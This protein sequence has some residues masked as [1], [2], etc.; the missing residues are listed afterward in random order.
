MGKKTN[1]LLYIPKK[2]NNE[3]IQ[4][5]TEGVAYRQ[6]IRNIRGAESGI[7]EFEKN[8]LSQANAQEKL[9]TSKNKRDFISTNL[10]SLDNTQRTKLNTAIDNK[11]AAKTSISEM[12]I[13][14]MNL[15]V[16]DKQ[17]KTLD[18]EI[19]KFYTTKSTQE[20]IAKEMLKPGNANKTAEEILIPGTKSTQQGRMEALDKLMEQKNKI[21]GKYHDKLPDQ[22]KDNQFKAETS[23]NEIKATANT[24]QKYDAKYNKNLFSSDKIVLSENITTDGKIRKID[25][26]YKITTDKTTGDVTLENTIKNKNDMYEKT[27]IPK[28][29]PDPTKLIDD[30]LNPGKQIIDPKGPLVDNPKYAEIQKVINGTATNF[31]RRPINIDKQIASTHPGHHKFS[32][33]DVS[34]ALK[35]Q[36]GTGNKIK[37]AISKPKLFEEQKAKIDAAKKD[38]KEVKELAN[39]GKPISKF[40]K[41]ANAINNKVGK[42]IFKTNDIDKLQRA[43]K[44]VDKQQKIVESKAQESGKSLQK[45][46]QKS[47]A[48][49]E[50]KNAREAITAIK[51]KVNETKAKTEKYEQSH[52]WRQ[53]IDKVAQVAAVGGAVAG[54]AAGGAAVAVAPVVGAAAFL[55]RAGSDGVKNAAKDVV[56]GAQ[57]FAKQVGGAALTAWNKVV[58]AAEFIAEKATKTPKDFSA[59][60]AEKTANELLNPEQTRQTKLNEKLEKFEKEGSTISTAQPAPDMRS[61]SEKVS[62]SAKKAVDAVKNIPNTIKKASEVIKDNAISAA[63]GIKNVVQHPIESTKNAAAGVKNFTVE[64]IESFQQNQKNKQDINDAKINSALNKLSENFKGAKVEPTPPD[65]KITT[66]PS[67]GG[68][69]GGK[70]GPSK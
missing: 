41:I 1:F 22:V 44:E 20:I 18:S 49:I 64:K 70:S 19:Q 31:E 21:T 3:F 68:P 6:N 54:M 30:V 60:K 48:D 26:E 4:G 13:D 36:I 38:I 11:I 67:G 57:N 59:A 27:V 63:Q 56:P 2:I 28:K 52:K 23:Y 35:E 9:D 58:S 7:N 16:I 53:G 45:A 33:Q 5:G 25:H 10:T 55:S 32:N 17:I 62:D 66:P 65:S 61:T 37:D 47:G 24:E 50:G 29:I 39:G 43:S 14:R 12:M 8:L 34:K 46:A 40:E 51:N 42:E 69:S 15:A